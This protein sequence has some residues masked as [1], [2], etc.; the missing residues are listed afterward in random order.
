ML[1]TL[2]QVVMKMHH[3]DDNTQDLFIDCNLSWDC[4]TFMVSYSKKYADE[5]SFKAKNMAAYVYRLLGNI[6]LKLF[7]PDMEYVKTLGWDEKTG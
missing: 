4:L 7:S 1:L 5:A 2:H 6:G 3:D